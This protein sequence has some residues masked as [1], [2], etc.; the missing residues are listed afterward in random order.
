MK[1]GDVNTK[2]PMV[3]V[4]RRNAIRCNI[5]GDEIES[6]FDHDFKMCGCQACGV[7]GGHQYI[8][9]LGNLEDYTELSVYEEVD[10]EESPAN[11]ACDAAVAGMPMASMSGTAAKADPF[12]N[13]G[14]N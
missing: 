14:K 8:R 13:C 4:L 6:F 3:K 1:A 12:P 2:K 9:R 10:P 11:E 5:C 7:D